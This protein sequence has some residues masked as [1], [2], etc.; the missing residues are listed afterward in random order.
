M[1]AK[2]KR[3]FRACCTL[4]CDSDIVNVCYFSMAAVMAEYATVGEALSGAAHS[5]SHATTRMAS[6]Q[7]KVKNVDDKGR[8]I[9]VGYLSVSELGVTFTYEHYPSVITQWPLTCIRRYGVNAIDGVFA[10]DVG[11]RSPTGE[12]RYAF[13][14][15]DAD[16]ICSRLDYLT[17]PSD[18][19]SHSWQS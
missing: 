9:H 3:A 13:R 8:I 15:A 5:S 14:T 16:E 7:Y 10:L 6:K 18:P 17:T 4:G 1:Y 11:R 19:R 12:G 2:Y